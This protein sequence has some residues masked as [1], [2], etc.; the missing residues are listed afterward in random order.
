MAVSFRRLVKFAALVALATGLLTGAARVSLSRYLSSNRGKA[1]VADRLGSALGMPVEVSEIDV[2]DDSSSFR[3]RVLDPADPKAEV[4]NVP[5]ASADVSAADFMTG[6]VAPSALK[7]AAPALTLRV[8][9]QGQVLT[10]L[11]A[12]PAAG[13]APAVVIENGSVRVRQ[14][15]RPEFALSGVNLKLEPAG[16]TVAL[17]GTIND[18]K[19]GRWTA[20]G[21]VNRNTRSGWVELTNPDAALD[22]EL[23]ATIPFVPLSMF[24][25]LP[26]G[27]RAAVTIRLEFSPDHDIQPTVEVRQTRR[28]FGIPSES[29]IR[30]APVS[31]HPHSE[32]MR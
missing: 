1:M 7:F 20:R 13:A 23:L 17:S 14:D 4:L 24:D 3:F 29:V 8:G 12:L 30:L 19:W 6:R 11:P 31:D 9:K 15:G 32:L 2:G 5:S 10:P 21:E 25:E 28:I 27:G 22:A 18:P 16:Q 26:V